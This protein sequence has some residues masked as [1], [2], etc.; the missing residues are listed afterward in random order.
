MRAMLART[1]ED[2]TRRFA[3]TFGATDAA[4]IVNE[5]IATVACRRAEIERDG[6]RGCSG[7]TLQ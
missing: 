5:F 1:R 2:L 6:S 7:V 4:Q 3:V